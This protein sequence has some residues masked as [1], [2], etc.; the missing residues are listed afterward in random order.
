M[1]ALIY[2]CISTLFFS[3]NLWF[4]R[5]SS[6]LTSLSSLQAKS[7]LGFFYIGLLPVFADHLIHLQHGG[8]WFL[9]LLGVVF[10]GDSMAYVFGMAWGKHKIMPS[11]SP[12]K[13][14]EGAAGG[15]LGSLIAALIAN[16]FLPH[17]PLFAIC[18]MG[19]LAGAVGQFGDF[20][21]SLLKRVADVKDS[22]SLM[23]GH[24]GVLDRLDGVIFAAPFVYLTASL[25]EAAATSH[26]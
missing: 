8:I 19:L 11:I 25:F 20:F 26:F 3:V 6:E 5:T 16:I 2:C 23:P 14:L 17:I 7:L 21:E 15:L 24:G 9:T 4:R 12:K 22:G 13:T 18:A 10:A 1:A